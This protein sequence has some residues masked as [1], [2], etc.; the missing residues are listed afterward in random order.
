MSGFSSL[1]TAVTGLV[2]AQRALD[3]ASQNVVNANTPGYSRQR[4]TL[5]SCGGAATATF[6]SGN[7]TVFGGVRIEDI[8]RVRD[9]FLEATRAA[10]GA[11]QSALDARAGAL[12]NAQ[13]LLAEPGDIGLQA[14][15]DG[16][17]SAWHDLASSPTN[18]SNG[19]VVI[20]QG[21][22]LT[23]QLQY[24]GDSL[25]AEWNNAYADLTD[26][27]SQVNQVASDLAGL[28]VQ[29][30]S[31]TVAGRPVNDLVDK[32]DL[33]VRKLGELVGGKVIPGV[34]NTVT[35]TVNGIS[36]VS[37]PSTQS[38]SVSGA[39]DITNAVDDPPIIVW[40]T[41][42][43]PVESGSAAGLLAALGTDLTRASTEANGVAV[44]LRD[45]VNALF[46]TGY[47]LDGVPGD[48]FFD[49]DSATTL[50]VVPTDPSQLAI[51]KDVGIV[52][53]SVAAAIGDLAIDSRA[54]EVLGGEKSPTVRWRE[55]TVSIGVQLQS[56]R[57][58]Q[59]VQRSVVAAADDA[60][61]SDAGVSLDEEMVNLLLFQRSFQAASRVITTIDEMMDTL[62][63]RTGTV[64]R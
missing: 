38:L 49:G 46:A 4:V 22:K 10:A 30:A 8:T 23:S 34:D 57:N 32:R 2:A 64:G 37:G 44:A 11:R 29:I 16:F 55:L 25:D 53:G 33:L 21:E 9:A 6:H 62:V 19:S 59:T 3:I 28:N 63:N 35:V 14:T 40:G 5:A 42:Q 1:N 18:T 58:A 52:D 47:T 31:G 20:Q 36:L 56:L 50:T 41:T 54:S 26:V 51:A 39:S 17:F 60:V 61:E 48:L 24:I 13:T 12:A 27:V 7:D 43:V 15:L 45:A